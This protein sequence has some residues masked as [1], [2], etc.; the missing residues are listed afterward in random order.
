MHVEALT[1]MN[2]DPFHHTHICRHTQT[3]AYNTYIQAHTHVHKQTIQ[4]SL[5]IAILHSYDYS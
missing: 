4:L 3:R 1:I 5:L 2:T